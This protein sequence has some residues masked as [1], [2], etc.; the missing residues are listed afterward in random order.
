MR[1]KLLML[2]RSG[3]RVSLASE[4]RDTPEYSVDMSEP[5][6]PPPPPPPPATEQRG[7]RKAA[8]PELVADDWNGEGRLM[9]HASALRDGCGTARDELEDSELLGAERGVYSSAMRCVPKSLLP[10]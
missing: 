4:Q 8:A 2:A 7:W 9:E 3:G 1:T 10:A 5:P 6:P